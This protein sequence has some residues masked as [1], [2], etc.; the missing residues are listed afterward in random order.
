MNRAEVEKFIQVNFAGI[1]QD[2]PWKDTPD[3]CVFR[4]AD[5]RKWFALIFEVKYSTLVKHNPQLFAQT[6]NSNP[7]Q[8]N[9]FYPN[10]VVDIVNLKSDPDLIETLTQ[11]SGILP[12]YHM[13]K[14]HWITILLDGS[15]PADRIKALI[16][17]SYNLTLKRR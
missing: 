17:M 8:T 3:Y 4:H 7:G 5:N 6:Q 2:Y 1:S 14:R 10:R 12:A 9:H 15:C 11:E 13:N 16:D